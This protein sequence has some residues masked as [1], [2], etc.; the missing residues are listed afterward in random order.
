MS[1]ELSNPGVRTVTAMEC[2]NSRGRPIAERSHVAA[3]G[4]TVARRAR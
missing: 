3:C 4:W 2:L 1:T